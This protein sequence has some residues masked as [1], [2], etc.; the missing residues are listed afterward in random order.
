MEEI[1]E[2]KPKKKQIVGYQP[3]G[4]KFLDGLPKRYLTLEE[5]KGLPKNLTDL[6]LKLKMYEVKHD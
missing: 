3:I 4:D 1:E 5:W 2:V 6:A